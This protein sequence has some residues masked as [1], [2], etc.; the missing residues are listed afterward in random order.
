MESPAGAPEGRALNLQAGLGMIIPNPNVPNNDHR[1]GLVFE[2]I[3][4][5]K[6]EIGW[7]YK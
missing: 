4:N 3:V 7:L 5:S 1:V 2:I 6:G